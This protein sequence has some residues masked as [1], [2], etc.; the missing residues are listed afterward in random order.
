MSEVMGSEDHNRNERIEDNALC[1][2]HHLRHQ[3]PVLDL[4]RKS[5]FL[6]SRVANGL[7]NQ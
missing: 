7:N 1:R 3:V 2:G 6:A 5:R 4:P